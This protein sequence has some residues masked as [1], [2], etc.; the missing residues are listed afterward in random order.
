MDLVIRRLGLFKYLDLPYLP[1][2]QPSPNISLLFNIY[3]L[4]LLP[5]SSINYY[6]SSKRKGN[7]KVDIINKLCL[8]SSGIAKTRHTDCACS[9]TKPLTQ[10]KPRS[11]LEPF[12][13]CRLPPSNPIN[14]YLATTRPDLQYFSI[15]ENSHLLKLT[16]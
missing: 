1:C 8:R 10:A 11:R 15:R 9:I 5:T 3:L 7:K 14:K 16:D 13:S 4:H 12:I 6:P 2:S